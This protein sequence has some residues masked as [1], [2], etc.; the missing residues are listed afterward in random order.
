MAYPHW[1]AQLHYS[2]KEDSEEK[3]LSYGGV[4]RREGYI[5]GGLIFQKIASHHQEKE[6]SEIK[7]EIS[8]T[9]G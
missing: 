2:T 8:S 5:M 7:N 1:S 4:R 6:I 3:R 9:H